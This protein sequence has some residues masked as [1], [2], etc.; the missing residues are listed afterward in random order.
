MKRFLCFLIL[1]NSVNTYCQEIKISG[2]EKLDGIC[3]PGNVAARFSIFTYT[4]SSNKRI[5]KI[6]KELNSKIKSLK[7]YS[8]LSEERMINLVINC[9]GAVLKS[10]IDTKKIQP[11][12]KSEIEN[13]FKMLRIW[14]KRKYNGETDSSILITFKIEN[15]VIRLK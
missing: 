1:I 10:E 4:S 3:N 5:K 7:T 12:V 2:Y 9:K 11:D 6:E 8:S 14:T 13:A 15:G